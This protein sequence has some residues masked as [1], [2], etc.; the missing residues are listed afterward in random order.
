MYIYSISKVN[1][2][3]TP[4]FINI[5]IYVIT[6]NQRKDSK[7][8]SSKKSSKNDSDVGVKLSRNINDATIGCMTE[9]P[10][11]N[12]AEITGKKKKAKIEHKKNAIKVKGEQIANDIIELE[13]LLILFLSMFKSDETSWPS[14]ALNSSNT[15]QV[16]LITKDTYHNAV[17][18]I[19]S[20]RV[21]KFAKQFFD[22]NNDT[23]K[24]Y[25]VSSARNHIYTYLTR[26]NS[27]INLRQSSQIYV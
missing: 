27:L 5:N 20:N 18:Q 23:E 4:A 12:L 15:S 22:N 1:F 19:P 24:I 6:E 8:N 21:V 7:K 25:L 17:K 16:K 14:L 26:P 3:P 10:N 13:K 9:M 11:I 2:I